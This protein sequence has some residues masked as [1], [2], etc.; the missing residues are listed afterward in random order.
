MATKFHKGSVHLAGEGF[1]LHA[2]NF[3]YVL[4]I[5]LVYGAPEV[6]ESLA[7]LRPV[8]GNAFNDLSARWGR[9]LFQCVCK[10]L[11]DM[12]AWSIHAFI[13]ATAVLDLP[14]LLLS[15]TQLRDQFREP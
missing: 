7:H 8:S 12:L 3:S 2:A 6:R 11:T 14:R 1:P 13:Y 5:T 10:S 15:G 4:R 9:K